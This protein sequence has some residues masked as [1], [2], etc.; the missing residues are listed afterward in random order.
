MNASWN[1]K[2]GCAPAVR[3]L[4]TSWLH[5]VGF[6]EASLEY[7]RENPYALDNLPGGEWGQED[8]SSW[9]ACLWWARYSAQ[10][11]AYIDTDNYIRACEVFNNF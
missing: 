8:W 11:L 10:G 5:R 4:A 2:E 6:R 9:D 7:A 3:E 1:A